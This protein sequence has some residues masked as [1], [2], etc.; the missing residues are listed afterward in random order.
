M[1]KYIFKY[2]DFTKFLD[3][4]LNEQI[5]LVLPS[6]WED[7]YE[8]VVFDKYIENSFKNNNIPTA[9]LERIAGNNL[10]ASC[11]TLCDESDAM[12]RIYNDNNQSVKIKVRYED[13]LNLDDCE[14]RTVNYI[15]NFNNLPTNLDFYDCFCFKRT[16]FEHEKEVR[17]LSHLK[18]SLDENSDFSA[19]KLFNKY[20]FINNEDY[21]TKILSSFKNEDKSKEDIIAFIEENTSDPVINSNFREKTK[22][23]HIPNIQNFIVSIELNP[24]APDWLDKTVLKFCELY[25]IKYI[26]KSELYKI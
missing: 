14:L 21:Q 18:Y 8:L 5:V 26:G 15:N 10:Y 2:L 22:S 23:V 24:L 12:W 6:I 7:P 25:N 20:L 17:L 19:E 13:L 1:E 3:M 16:A 9:V 11:W 4:V